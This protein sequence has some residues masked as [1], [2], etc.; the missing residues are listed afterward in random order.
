[1]TKTFAELIVAVE[2]D[3]DGKKL[4]RIRV[5]DLRHGAASLLLASGADMALVSKRLGHS[6]ISITTD[7]YSHLLDGVGRQA[8][9]R[10]AALVPRKRD[11]RDQ[12]TGPDEAGDHPPESA[13]GRTPG[14]EETPQVRT[15][16]PPGT[17]TPNPLVK[18]QLLCQLS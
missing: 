15:G 1:V 6:S 16:A 8:A 12:T 2:P 17:R 3:D 10:A 7:T 11:Q 5:H 18:S 13:G 14:E 9:N 4:R